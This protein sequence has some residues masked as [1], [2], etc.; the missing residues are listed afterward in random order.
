MSAAGTPLDT[1][2]LAQ[3]VGHPGEQSGTVFKITVGRDDLAMKDH[4]AVINARMGLNT[5]AACVGT[6]QDAAIA[7]DIAMLEGEVIPVLKTL[8]KNGIDVVAI[9]HHMT[10][11]QPIVIFLHYGGRGS[12]EKLANAF[13]SALNALG[14]SAPDHDHGESK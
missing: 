14:Q 13:K 10:E 6:Q 4:G 11:E 12:A 3:I 8:R 1:E 9:H 7:G 5:W 2:K